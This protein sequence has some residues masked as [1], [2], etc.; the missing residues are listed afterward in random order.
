M[1]NEIEDAIVTLK[2]ARESIIKEIARSGVA[3]GYGRALSHAVN[4]NA[5]CSAIEHA[6]ILKQ[7]SAITA[8]VTK[9]S[10]EKQ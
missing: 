6:E 4:L 10:A 2:R 9:K 8:P 7:A 5:V 3:G 1:N